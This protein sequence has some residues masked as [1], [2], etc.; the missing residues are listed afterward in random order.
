[1]SYLSYRS[2][3]LPHANILCPEITESNVLS[4]EAAGYR[5]CDHEERVSQLRSST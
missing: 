5:L 1:M 2:Q 4:C 3:R